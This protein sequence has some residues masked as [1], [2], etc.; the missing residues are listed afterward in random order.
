MS[1][2]LVLR[3]T[4]SKKV[5][6]KMKDIMEGVNTLILYL[7]VPAVIVMVLSTIFVGL[8][9]PTVYVLIVLAITVI[10]LIIKESVETFLTLRWSKLF[11][12]ANREIAEM[13]N[14]KETSRIVLENCVLSI[15]EE[16]RRIAIVSHTQCNVYYYEDISDLEL[17]INGETIGKILKVRGKIIEEENKTET[18]KLVDKA[19]IK[20]TFNKGM[21]PITHTIVILNT[22]LPFFKKVDT[23]DT[24]VKTAKNWFKKLENILKD[25][26]K[27]R[28]G[29]Q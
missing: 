4:N 23:S 29:L 18:P 17:L 12:R 25:I 2:K 21:K 11:N 14:Y 24:G 27:D 1:C 22:R 9:K 3:E 20:I 8:T 26:E 7:L 5:G 19:E 13:V 16:E 15:S 10:I 6:N 28:G